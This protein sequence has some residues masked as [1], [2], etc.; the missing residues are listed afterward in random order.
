[1]SGE[2]REMSSSSS[3]VLINMQ[4]PENNFV[5]MSANKQRKSQI[6]AILDDRQYEV[7]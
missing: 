1:M 3:G 4:N 2:L 7:N 6:K 5:Q